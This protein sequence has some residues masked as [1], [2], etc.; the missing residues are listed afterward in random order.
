MVAFADAFYAILANQDF[1]FFVFDDVD[2]FS[3][4]LS[5]RYAFMLT[6]GMAEPSVNETNPM[7]WMIF[8]TGTFFNL[9]LMLNL[10]IAIISS[11]YD[12]VMAD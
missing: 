9:I 4:I 7:F 6:A 3:F 8:I 11:S 5:L 2:N 12:T 1:D 10:L